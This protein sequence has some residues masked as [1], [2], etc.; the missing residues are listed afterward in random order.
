MRKASF[1]KLPEALPICE[2]SASDKP[3]DDEVEGFKK[4]S[5]SSLLLDAIKV[6]DEMPQ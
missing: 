5:G 1:W 3:S 2:L 4:V 6:F